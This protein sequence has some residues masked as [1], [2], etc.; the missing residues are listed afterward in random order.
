M[1]SGAIE[2]DGN[3]VNG[4]TA[5]IIGAEASLKFPPERGN[6]CLC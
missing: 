5:R 1:I 6:P 4:A 3:T 2:F